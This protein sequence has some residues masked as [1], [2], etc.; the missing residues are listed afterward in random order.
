MT[1]AAELTKQILVF[2]RTSTAEARPIQPKVIGKEALKLLRASLPSTIEFRQE[3]ASDSVVLADPGEIHRIVVNLCMNAAHAMEEAGGVLQ[4]SLDDVDLDA[5]YVAS[6]PDV[7]PG[8]FVRLTVKDSGCGMTEEVRSRVFEPYFTTRA[9]GK[10]T[11]LGL[12][13][14]HGIVSKRH[15]TVSVASA[16]GK[17][18]TFQILLPVDAA[19]LATA[20]QAERA[21]AMGTERVLFVDDE[22]MM[23]NLAVRSLG[24]LGYRVTAMTSSVDALARLRAAPQDFDVV[25]TDTTMPHLTGD[26]LA[27]AIRAFAPSMPIILCTG[28]S[29]RIDEAR[30]RD[31]GIDELVMK[32]V[33]G[34]DLSHVIRRVLSVRRQSGRGVAA[35]P[36]MG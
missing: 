33:A 23:A 9:E 16:V 30:A 17:G 18:S 29:E 7:R 3:L 36:G 25:V 21:P 15:G 12:S 4:V 32:P 8:R 14:V 1:R 19:H 28:F 6:S 26:R 22:P 24:R 5:A 35:A 31:L 27:T 2:S 10:G 13:V 34:A 11:G 20:A